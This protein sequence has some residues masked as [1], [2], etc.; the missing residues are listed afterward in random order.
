[1]GKI[2]V[3]SRYHQ[4][5]RQ[6]VAINRGATTAEKLAPW[7]L[8]FYS[9]IVPR[10][11]RKISI[12]CW[13]IRIFY[14]S[15]GCGRLPTSFRVTSLALTESYHSLS[16]LRNHLKSRVNKPYRSASHDTENLMLMT[17]LS[18][19]A[20]PLVTV[21]DSK[22]HGANMGPPGPRWVPCWP[23]ELRYLGYVLVV[24]PVTIKLSPWPFRFTLENI[25]NKAKN[26]SSMF[27]GI[28]CN[29]LFHDEILMCMWDVG[30]YTGYW[31][32]AMSYR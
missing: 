25:Y 27:Y 12:H 30:K 1:M 17:T 4:I 15:H 31:W 19:L 7:Q 21:P 22:V 16:L 6:A 26:N 28:H 29:R 10:S 24:P 23:H 9:E 32:A 18:F 2:T 20:A 8:S 11:T 14:D 13:T 3:Y 5:A